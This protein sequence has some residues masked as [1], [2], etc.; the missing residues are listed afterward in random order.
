MERLWALIHSPPYSAHPQGL[1][2]HRHL[3][4]RSIV[5]YVR[6]PS[7][8][9]YPEGSFSFLA[10]EPIHIMPYEGMVIL[11]DHSLY[12]DGFPPTNSMGIRI[13]LAADFEW[14]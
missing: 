9:R 14:V 3:C 2:W 1:I 6:V 11:F 8:L 13:V 7:D 12:H 4:A 5:Y 10:P